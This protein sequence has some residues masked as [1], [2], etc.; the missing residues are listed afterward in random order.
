MRIYTEHFHSIYLI[1]IQHFW[2]NQYSQLDNSNLIKLSSILFSYEE[3]LFSFGVNDRDFGKNGRELVKIFTKKAF[4]NCSDCISNILKIERDVK[5]IKSPNGYLITNG[6]NDLFD[7]LVGI[8]DLIKQYKHYYIHIQVLQMFNECF[9]QYLIGVDCVVSNDS[10]IIDKDFQLAIAN[11]SIIFIEKLSK[12]IDDWERLKVITKKE[13]IEAMGF[14]QIMIAINLM[15]QNVVKR[16]VS[17]FGITLSESFNVTFLDLN[18]Q[19]VLLVIHDLFSLYN[20]LMNSM[21]TRKV[22]EEILKLTTFYYIKLLLTTAYKTV[23]NVDQLTNKIN[24]DKELL[25]ETFE[26]VVGKN[27]TQ[28]N[29][30]I[31]SDIH[32]FLEISLYMISSSCYI[33]REYVGSSFNLNMVKALINLRCDFSNKE[34]KEAIAEC[35]EVLEKF[36]DKTMEKGTRGFFEKMEREIQIENENDDGIEENDLETI[37]ENGH[38]NNSNEKEM[39]IEEK[40]NENKNYYYTLEEFL[41]G[42]DTNIQIDEYQENKNKDDSIILSPNEDEDEIISDISDVVY[43]GL[44]TKKTYSTWQER[45]FQLKNSYLYW[46]KDKKSLK[47]QNKIAIDCILRIDSYKSCK[48]LIVLSDKVNPNKGKVY[49]FCLETEKEKE[50]WMKVITQEMKKIKGE[51]NKSMEIYL[52]IKPK[53]KVIHD[54][55]KLP[56]IGKERLVFKDKILSLMKN[57]IYF[58]PFLTQK[59]MPGVES[60]NQ[61][62]KK[63]NSLTLHEEKCDD[64]QNDDI[65]SQQEKN[66]QQV[67]C[68]KKVWGVILSLF[69]KKNGLDKSDAKEY[70][71]H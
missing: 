60:N 52:E 55:F 11:N 61:R 32:D 57:E 49:K 10:I 40:A 37:K 45:Y 13:I 35:K 28:S 59:I 17:E 33:I 54:Y 23:K 36:V 14:K 38:S 2:S 43:Q 67:S 44:M 47:I 31:L 15:N 70:F 64:K 39:T 25:F 27:L 4:K 56:E 1:I 7:T 12:L 65:A 29:M 16:F 9:I 58:K 66:G 34:K 19:K 51:S 24:T 71:N 68:V 50:N 8:F 6:P 62:K 42:K 69:K 5:S 18:M 46:F 53:K 48:F 63:E 21:I 41:N 22:Y 3:K 30:K 26:P 20:P